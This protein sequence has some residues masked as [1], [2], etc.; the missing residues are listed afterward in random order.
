MFHYFIK[1]SS[2]YHPNNLE[3]LAKIFRMAYLFRHRIKTK[4]TVQLC[5]EL[6][7]GS[8]TFIAVRFI[9]QS[10]LDSQMKGDIWRYPCIVY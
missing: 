9:L 3:N 8:H 2:F 6:I 10:I 4:A 7:F 5:N 1:M